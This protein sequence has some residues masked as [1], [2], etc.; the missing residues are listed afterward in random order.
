MIHCLQNLE[1][2]FAYWQTPSYLFPPPQKNDQPGSISITFN[3]FKCFLKEK[4]IKWPQKQYQNRA[5]C[6]FI[7]S[8]NNTVI[9][10]THGSLSRLA[11][12]KSVSRFFGSKMLLLDSSLLIHLLSW[13]SSASEWWWC[14]LWWMG[15]GLL[16]EGVMEGVRV[17]WLCVGVRVK[18]VCEFC[19]GVEVL[20]TD[21]LAWTLC[22]KVGECWGSSEGNT[23]SC[24][25][26]SEWLRSVSL[27]HLSLGGVQGG[28]DAQKGVNG[29]L[30]DEIKLQLAVRRDCQQ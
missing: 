3:I 7:H 1:F 11:S 28:E 12:S 2:I 10:R 9:I 15:L 29:R 4:K 26:L 30:R 18:L 6:E 21:N 14:E 27:S 23:Q 25:G 24:V 17:C 20:L 8:L 13:L 5:A 22:E 16:L 19:S